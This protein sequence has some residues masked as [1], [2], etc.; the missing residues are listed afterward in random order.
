MNGD[1]NRATGV[2]PADTGGSGNHRVRYRG[3]AAQCVAK[4]IEI[5]EGS[6]RQETQQACIVLEEA[7]LWI[8]DS[9]APG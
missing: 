4:A 2:V 3:R 9:E 5:L 7:L 8:E 6:S 1:S